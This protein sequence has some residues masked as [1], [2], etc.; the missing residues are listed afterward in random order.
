MPTEE[1]GT[2]PSQQNQYHEQNNL[3]HDAVKEKKKTNHNPTLQT[4]SLTS[5]VNCA[6]MIQLGNNN[7]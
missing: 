3:H 4:K 5:K 6:I 2:V 1:L 7:K